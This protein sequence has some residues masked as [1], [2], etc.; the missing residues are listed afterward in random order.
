MNKSYNK[1]KLTVHGSIAELTQ[2]TVKNFGSD[3]GILLN[4]PVPPGANPTTVPIG[5]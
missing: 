1:P 4:I 5:S 2:Q 3:D